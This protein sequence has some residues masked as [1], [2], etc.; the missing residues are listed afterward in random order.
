MHNGAV[1]DFIPIRRAM[2]NLMSDAVFANIL[3]STDSEHVAGLYMTYLTDGADKSSFENVY[4]ASK[5]AEAMHKAVATVIELQRKCIGDEKRLPNS[6]NLCATDGIKLVAYR[7][8]NHATSQP[9]TL[10]YSTKA[11]TTLNRKYPD[12]ADG[13]HVAG[14]TDVGRD[15]NEHGFHLIVASEPST[16]KESE[17]ELIGKNQ[18]VVVD[19]KGG[20]KIGDVPY[21]KAW[22]AEDHLS[23][24]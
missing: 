5:M 18:F 24:V 2:N 13:V 1:S 9:P 16:Y 10:Y 14:V 11:G 20:F 8:R 15:A 23:T 21:D 4:P 12:A 19:P 22:D 7:F 3:G 6:L 17:W